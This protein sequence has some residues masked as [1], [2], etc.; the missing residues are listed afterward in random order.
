V[1]WLRERLPARTPEGRPRRLYVTRG[2]GRHTR[3]LE[4]E[5]ELW[6]ELERRGFTRI[7]PGTMSVQDQIDHFAAAEVIVGIHGAA[8]TNLVFAAPGARVLHL[9]APGYVKHCFFAILDAVP[10]STYR[11]LVGDGTPTPEGTS[12]Q[13]IMDDVRL[14]PSRILAAVDELL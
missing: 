6:P 13:G 7:D 4:S 2:G 14:P 8:L 1:Q 9:F 10:G 5:P 11:Y 12:M 3:R